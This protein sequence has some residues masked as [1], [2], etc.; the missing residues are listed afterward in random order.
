MIRTMTMMALVGLLF[1]VAISAYAHSGN[2]FQ[3]GPLVALALALSG[4]G[5]L[6]SGIMIL[7]GRPRRQAAT[8]GVFSLAMLI[9]LVILPLVWPYP[10]SPSP[11]SLESRPGASQP[12]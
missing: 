7:V 4:L 11:A 1:G 3:T 5:T 9:A 6:A 10:S 2:G 12:R 8:A